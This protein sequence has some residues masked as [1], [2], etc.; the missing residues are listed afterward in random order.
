MTYHAVCVAPFQLSNQMTY[1]YETWY[2]GYVIGGQP[3]L[4]IP[5][6]LQ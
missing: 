1:F 5:H 4:E 3:K 6:F 2:E